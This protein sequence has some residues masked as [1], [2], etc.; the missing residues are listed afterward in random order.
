MGLIFQI[1]LKGLR[2]TDPTAGV[3]YP[4]SLTESVPKKLEWRSGSTVKIFFLNSESESFSNTEIAE[5]F[6]DNYT[7][8]IGKFQGNPLANKW[9]PE[10]HGLG[11]ISSY[12]VLSNRKPMSP[13]SFCR[14]A[15]K[16]CIRCVGKADNR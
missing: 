13:N 14:E 7:K 16:D 8:Q 5:R 12:K 6:S 3:P 1:F 9:L 10:H 2:V 11:T 15:L 4:W